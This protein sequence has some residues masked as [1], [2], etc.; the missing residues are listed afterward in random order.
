ME[1]EQI[2]VYSFS[3]AADKVG[4]AISTLRYWYIAI[5]LLPKEVKDKLPY[6]LPKKRKSQEDMRKIEWTGKDIEQ[7]KDFSDW[8]HKGGGR[9][10]FRIYNRRKNY[11]N[12][13]SFIQ[14]GYK[15]ESK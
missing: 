12:Y 9:G 11:K 14:R 5:Q 7:L 8:F 15:Y 10:L 3:E 4:V 13:K 2:K 6:T 1:Q